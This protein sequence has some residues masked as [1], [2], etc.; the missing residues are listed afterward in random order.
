MLWSIVLCLLA[1]TQY[2]GP[3][4]VESMGTTKLA[5]SR[6]LGSGTVPLII[7]RLTRLGHADTRHNVDR[8]ERYVYNILLHDI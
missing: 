6:V 2:L 8:L 3:P 7:A 5:S 1:C 4:K